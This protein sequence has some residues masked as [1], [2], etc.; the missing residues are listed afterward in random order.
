MQFFTSP[1][2]LKGWVKSQPSADAASSKIL[3]L[4]T[5]F[6]QQELVERRPEQDSI[7]ETCKK[8]Y[9]QVEEKDAVDSQT[10]FGIL[11]NHNMAQMKL[12]KGA[13]KMN[14]IA[15]PISRQRNN[16]VRGNRNKWNRTVDGFNEGTPWRIDRDKMF[17]FTHYY[18]DDLKFDEDPTH[19][20]SGEAIWRMYIMDKFTADYQDEKGRVAGGYINDRFYRFPDA[21]TPANP[22][23]D[24]CQGN[25]MELAKGER[26][27]KPRP[28]QFSTERR[29]EEARG[30]K[31]ED[32]SAIVAQTKSVIK[33]SSA[34]PKEKDDD[35]VYNIFKD[36]ID[37]REAGIEYG[38]MIESIS[39]HYEVSILGVTQIDQAAQQIKAKHNGIVYV[40]ERSS[41]KVVLADAQNGPFQVGNEMVNVSVNN[42]TFTLKPETIFTKVEGPN[43]SFSYKIIEGEDLTGTLKPN[44]EFSLS[45]IDSLKLENKVLDINEGMSELSGED[46]TSA[47]QGEQ[48]PTATAPL[49][50]S[51]TDPMASVAGDSMA[52]AAKAKASFSK[53][54]MLDFPINE[55]TQ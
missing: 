26:S 13:S 25:Q 20:Y 40:S 45:N 36:T 41:N 16:W 38:K 51:P 54:S 43:G 49:E 15:Q 28:H 24:R 22:D 34:Q 3:G 42:Q 6:P 4:I 12:S 5:Q 47:P 9:D 29:L 17:N 31:S 44:S 7:I 50:Q 32:L 1:E 52:V 37:M 53:E 30:N 21:G 8:I 33:L 23:V 14:K 35:K 39:D 48:A 2:D 46:T 10:L 11:S 55:V 27:R 19:I 18:T